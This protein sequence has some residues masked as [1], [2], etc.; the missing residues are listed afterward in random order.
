MV[1][2]IVYLM[3]LQYR[4]SQKALEFEICNWVYNGLDNNAK[5]KD[6][7]TY[8][9]A[10]EIQILN[11]KMTRLERSACQIR[12]QNKNEIKYNA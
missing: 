11:L 6:N 12:D 4:A 3:Q 1:Q 2:N 9:L 7:S 5:D 8:R 10:L